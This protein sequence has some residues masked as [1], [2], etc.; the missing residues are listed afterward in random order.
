MRSYQGK[1][2]MACYFFKHGRLHVFH[3]MFFKKNG[4]DPFFG[5]FFSNHF[6]WMFRLFGR[7]FLSKLSF[8]VPRGHKDKGGAPPPKKK[9]LKKMSILKKHG[10]LSN[11]EIHLNLGKPDKSIF[12]GFLSFQGSEK[13]RTN[14]SCSLVIFISSTFKA[15]DLKNQTRKRI[16]FV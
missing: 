12:R 6:F 2:Q 1:K 16:P 3:G 13:P 15:Y 5:C 10:F 9:K 14:Q 11:G 7:L 4:E 8:L